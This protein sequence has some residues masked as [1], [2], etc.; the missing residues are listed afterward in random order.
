MATAGRES[1]DRG[2][3]KSS[4]A[5]SRAGVAGDFVPD[6][7]VLNNLKCDRVIGLQREISRFFACTDEA[8]RIR[9]GRA[10]GYPTIQSLIQE[11][12]F[13]QWAAIILVRVL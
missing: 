4:V 5:K 8:F 6:L 1:A 3:R 10:Q 13:F 7:A 9:H 2:Q 11:N 12:G